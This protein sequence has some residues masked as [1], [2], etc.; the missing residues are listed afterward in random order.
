V[1][2]AFFCVGIIKLHF[3]D[4]GPVQ[5]G[6]DLEMDPGKP[7]ASNISLFNFVYDTSAT[8]WGEVKFA[9]DSYR[10]PFDQLKDSSIYDQAAV[11]KL[12]P[13]S[14]NSLGEEHI[15]SISRGEETDDDDIVPMIDVMDV[16][17]PGD[18]KIY[19]WPLVKSASFN[20]SGKPIAVMDDDFLENGPYDLLSLGEVP[21]QIMPASPASHLSSMSRLTNNLMRK[22]SKRARNHRKIY[23]YNTAG[24][25]GARNIQKGGDDE[26]I[27]VA[28]GTE[29]ETVEIGGVD[30]KTQQF[31]GGVVQL[32]DRMAGNLSSMLGLGN[33]SPTLGQERMIQQSV[34]RREA[35]MQ[36]QVVDSSVRLIKKLGYLLWSDVARTATTDIQIPGASGYSVESVWTPGDREGEFI[37]YDIDIDMHSMPYQSPRDRV[38]AINELIAKIYGPM[39]EQFMAQGG[40]IDMQAITDIYAELMNLPQ[41]RE[42]IRFANVTADP[43]GPPESSKPAHTTREYIRRSAGPDGTSQGR[44]MAEQQAWQSD[45]NA[46]AM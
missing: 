38:N 13:T 44:A 20:G 7:F 12:S 32:Y 15:A 28:D 37:N 46:E 22:Q 30:A 35:R 11:R 27:H 29:I 39:G 6:I 40:Q 24:A 43:S 33:Q 34:G 9:A 41:L 5:L 17:H 10:L 45:A 19:T 18:G 2:D 42:I 3:A 36:Y 16:W 1:L 25:E 14:K 26:F 8:K 23:S 4:S 31:L 21:E